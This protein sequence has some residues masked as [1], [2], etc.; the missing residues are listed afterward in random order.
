MLLATVAST[1]AVMLGAPTVV[2]TSPPPVYLQPGTAQPAPGGQTQLYVIGDSLTAGIQN[3]LPPMLPGW[4]VGTWGRGG[5]PLAEGMDILARTII[6]ADGSII[7]GM[8]LGTNAPPWDW[9]ALRAAV[10]ESLRRVGPLGCVIWATIVRPARQWG[11]S[12]DS[13]NAMLRRLARRDH[14]IL[15]VDWERRLREHPI[16]MDGTGVHP[17]TLRGWTLRARMFAAAA[18]GCGAAASGGDALSGTVDQ[19]LAIPP[20]PPIG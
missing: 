8:S 7:L 10:A 9:A 19:R 20:R 14:R 4:G 11:T 17:R 15:L 6:P 18:R 1:V 5:R 13:E 16:S 2:P 3:V 12:Y